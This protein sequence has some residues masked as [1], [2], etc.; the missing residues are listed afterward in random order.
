[1]LVQHRIK[2][3]SAVL[4]GRTVEWNLASLARSTR[5]WNLAYALAASAFSSSQ[6]TL[7][8][9]VRVIHG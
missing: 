4:Q 3:C 7:R 5:V 8:V 2:C 6:D 1:M 9:R